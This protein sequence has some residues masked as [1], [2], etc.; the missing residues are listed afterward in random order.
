VPNE[1]KWEDWLCIVCVTFC[2]LPCF[3]LPSHINSGAELRDCV[4][5]DVGVV[6]SPKQSAARGP[7]GSLVP[8]KIQ[9]TEICCVFF[10]S[11]WILFFWQKTLFWIHVFWDLGVTLP[12]IIA[13]PYYGQLSRY[14]D[15]LRT[16]RS[17]H[18]ISMGARFSVLIQTE[19]GAYP[20]S[21]T[22][23]TRALSPGGKAAESWRWAPTPINAEVKEGLELYLYYPFTPS[24][25][26]LGWILPLPLPLPFTAIIEVAGS[27]HKAIYSTGL[28]ITG[29]EFRNSTVSWCMCSNV[30][31]L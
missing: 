28:S 1:E 9:N 30:E 20:A 12:I 25:P 8:L 15:L 10:F 22:V 7:R 17:G 4:V 14:S 31:I 13:C 18:R 19:F 16:W 24:W 26:Y 29:S 2:A 5:G 23:G 3:F 11:R 27:P 21:C 6:K